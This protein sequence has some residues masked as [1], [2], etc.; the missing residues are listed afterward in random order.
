VVTVPAVVD[1]ATAPLIPVLDRV[2][3]S[4]PMTPGVP[5]SPIAPPLVPAPI[6]AAP[7]VLGGP[8]SLSGTASESAS[9]TSVG[10]AGLEA[11]T[12]GPALLATPDGTSD[13][14][15]ARG[16]LSAATAATAAGAGLLGSLDDAIGHWSF[17]VGPSGSASATGLALLLLAL[18]SSA[19]VF[20]AGARSLRVLGPLHLGPFRRAHRPGFSPD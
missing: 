18:A 13:P 8:S 9:R 10:A 7:V 2:E 19:G 20:G 12:S 14:T 6:Q 15:A 16:H 11:H 17:G 3:G 4:L 1:R 5:E